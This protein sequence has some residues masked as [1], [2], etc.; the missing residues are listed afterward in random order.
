M[1]KF[2]SVYIRLSMILTLLLIGVFGFVQSAKAV[3]IIE[4]EVEATPERDEILSFINNSS[5]GIMRGY[6]KLGAKG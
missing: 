3:E 4:A 2:R 5:R 6:S 1:N